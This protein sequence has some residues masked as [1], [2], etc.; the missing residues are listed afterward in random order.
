MGIT[1]AGVSLVASYAVVL[2]I[3]YVFT[4][5]LFAVPYEW[6][7]LGQAVGLA[8]ILVLIGELLTPTDGF[9]GLVERTALWFAY[10]LLLWVTGFLN[11]EERAAAGRVLSPATVRSALAGL[12]AAPADG[13]SEPEP[14]RLRTLPGPRLTR[15]ALEAEQRDEDA[16]R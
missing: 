4:Q 11:D 12:R 6:L 7:R 2:V 13:P 10:P 14:A 1:G 15:E 3:M 16:I 5:R 8:A 9:D